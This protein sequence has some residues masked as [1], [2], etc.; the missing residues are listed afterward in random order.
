MVVVAA[1]SRETGISSQRAEVGCQMLSAA[2]TVPNVADMS[3][4]RYQGA[5]QTDCRSPLTTHS[6]EAQSICPPE[7]KCHEDAF[8]VVGNELNH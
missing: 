1:N 7:L 2:L 4:T 5:P 8:T 3:F 6:P